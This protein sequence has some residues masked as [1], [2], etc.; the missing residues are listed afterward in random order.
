MELSAMPWL[1]AVFGGAAI[2]GLAIAYGA[3][4][5]R[6]A[7]RR[8]REAAEQGARDLYHKDQSKS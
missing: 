5:S 3:L 8:Q 7:S 6:K 2:L 1:F 4:K